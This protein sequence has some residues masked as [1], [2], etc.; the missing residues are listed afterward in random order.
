MTDPSVHI[1]TTGGTIAATPSGMLTGADLLATIPDLAALATVT[2]EQLL[3]IGSSLITPMH[4]VQL[5]VRVNALW[6]ERPDLSGIV[7]THG[8]DTL[9]ETAYFLHLTNQDSRPIVLT[10]A[11]RSANALS[12]DGPANLRAAI[13][14][15]AAPSAQNRGALVLLNDEIHTARDVAKTHT[16]RLDAF[17]SGTAGALGT[18]YENEISWLRQS[19]NAGLVRTPFT[20]IPD[21]PLPRVDIIYSYAGA[22]GDMIS[23]AVAA[24]A[25][26]LVI[27]SFG[28]GRLPQGQIAAI[29]AALAQGVVVVVSSRVGSGRV[30]PNYH[31][32]LATSA[33]GDGVV[34]AGDLNPQKARVLLLLAL[35]RALEIAAILEES[36]PNTIGTKV[37][38]PIF[39]SY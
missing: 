20:L 3:D 21:Q 6:R 12:A 18:I 24:G 13:V 17:A 15:A 8:T 33:E 32:N 7:I 9:E 31:Y 23:A 35:T 39:A 5:A 1:L 22:T 34:L 11:M 10:G 29:Q 26:G 2:V 27:A 16:L 4:W 25:Q 19:E 38:Q 36:A 28:S 14:V 37:V 30:E